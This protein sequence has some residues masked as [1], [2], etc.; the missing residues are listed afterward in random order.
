[1]KLGYNAA[2]KPQIGN[3]QPAEDPATG[4]IPL[5]Q[6]FEVEIAKALPKHLTAERMTRV[7]ITEVRK[8]PKLAQCTQASF[9]AAII[10]C[11]QLGLEPGNG[12]GLA[13][14]I[15]YGREC[16]FMVGAGGMVELAGR[17]GV[18]IRS[19]AVYEQ[20]YL[21]YKEGF[22][23]VI[24]HEPNLKVADRGRI[25]GSY[26]IARFKDGFQQGEFCTLQDIE[27]ARSSSKSANNGPWKTHFAE[28]ARKTAIRKLFKVIP[29]TP[30][31]ARALHADTIDVEATP[32]TQRIDEF[33]DE[34]KIA[35]DVYG[36]DFEEVEAA[37]DAIEAE[38]VK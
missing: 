33:R 18:R 16:Q 28:M 19:Q 11:A 1:M 15:P 10:Q 2:N 34:H 26:A 23:Q 32:I 9:F 36:G 21:K 17:N 31:I 24:E 22:D 29:K 13:Y 37:L 3:R 12:L 30:E 5:I 4:L 8:N 35:D 38:D 25:I 20:D 6:K 7:F 27:K 14:L